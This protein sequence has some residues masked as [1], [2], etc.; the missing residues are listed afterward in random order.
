MLVTWQV[1]IFASVVLTSVA[2]LLQRVLLKDEKSDPV[3]FSIFFQLLTGLL[4]GVFGVFFSD[5]SFP[6][7]WSGVWFNI[8]LMTVLYAL[9]NVFIFKSLKLIEASTFTVIFASR[10]LFTTLAST[11]LLHEGLTLVRWGEHCSSFSAWC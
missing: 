8:I 3:S 10:A 6:P 11:M 1:F 7:Q 4:I 2:T 9:G 5:M